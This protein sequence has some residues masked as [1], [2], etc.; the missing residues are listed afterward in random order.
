MRNFKL[1]GRPVHQTY[2]T[3]AHQKLLIKLITFRKFTEYNISEL[4]HTHT[5]IHA[6]TSTHAHLRMQIRTHNTSTRT[7]A[8]EHARTHTH[9]THLL[10]FRCVCVCTFVY[11]YYIQ[12]HT[13]TSKD[14]DACTNTHA[15]RQVSIQT[16]SRVTQN[17]LMPQFTYRIS[18][19]I[20]DRNLQHRQRVKPICLSVH[21]P[22]RQFWGIGAFATTPRFWAGGFVGN[23]DAYG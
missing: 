4:T 5:H 7:H 19:Q 13:H 9:M 16:D 12:T 14:T 22:R 8:R 23:V 2:R 17:Y 21:A 20:P 11:N 15:S 18:N 3:P 1:R 6:H 10:Q